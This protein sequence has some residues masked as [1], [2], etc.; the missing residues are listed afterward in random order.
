MAEIHVERKRKSLWW[1]WLLILIILAVIAYYWYTNN[2][3]G[4][5]PISNTNSVTSMADTQDLL[6]AKYNI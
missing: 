4:G 6:L 2:Y 1:L 5:T 3:Q